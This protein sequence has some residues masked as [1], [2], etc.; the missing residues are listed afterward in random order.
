M[1]NTCRH[2]HDE[3]LSPSAIQDW[4]G[5]GQQSLNYLFLFVLLLFSPICLP[6]GHLENQRPSLRLQ[7]QYPVTQQ[8]SHRMITSALKLGLM[9]NSNLYSAIL[10]TDHVISGA[11]RRSHKITMFVFARLE[12]SHMQDPGTNVM[13]HLLSAWNLPL[14]TFFPC[15]VHKFFP[16]LILFEV[17]KGMSR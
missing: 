11:S 4:G 2:L 14:V 6:A 3:W 10:H 17:I 15:L 12:I 8:L 1:Q 7:T 13:D 9:W 16:L 5:D